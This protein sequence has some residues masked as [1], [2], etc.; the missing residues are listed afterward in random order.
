VVKLEKL[1]TLTTLLDWT[2]QAEESIS[3]SSQ[4]NHFIG[5]IANIRHRAFIEIDRLQRETEETR[6]SGSYK[7]CMNGVLMD[8]KYE[9]GAEPSALDWS[10]RLERIRGAIEMAIE[11]LESI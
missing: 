11:G 1:K 7:D 9:P 3:N 8:C 4:S 2:S 10:A 5:L 6:E